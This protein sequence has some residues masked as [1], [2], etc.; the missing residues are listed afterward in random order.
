MPEFI[1]KEKWPPSSPDLNP[2]DFRIWSILENKVSAYHHK[3]EEALKATLL[4]KW[5]KLHKQS[6][7]I[8]AKR[9]ASV[10]SRLSMPTEDILKKL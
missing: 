5:G 3:N 9:S 4:K 7:V 2:L 10:C 8:L 1:S 6:F